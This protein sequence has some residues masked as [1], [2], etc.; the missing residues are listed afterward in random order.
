M[1][2]VFLRTESDSKNETEV[3]H[4]FMQRS[5]LQYSEASATT[6]KTHQLFLI[7]TRFQ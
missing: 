2:Y 7:Q 3:K 1:E 6:E 5:H 4:I